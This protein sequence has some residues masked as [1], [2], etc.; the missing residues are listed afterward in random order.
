M[1]EC[2]VGDPIG[3]GNDIGV[4]DIKYMGYL[5]NHDDGNGRRN[6]NPSSADINKSRR[7]QEEA[8]K[9]WEEKKL[10]DA[11]SYINSAIYYN[12]ND[13]ENW[14]VKGL[15]LWEMA[16]MDSS[17]FYEACQCFN[18]ALI[19]KPDGKII[20]KNKAR[21]I[22]D[23]ARYYY[24]INDYD[25][26]MSR[27][28]ESLS[29]IEDKTADYYAT[30]LNLKSCIYF[31]EFDYGKAL[32]YINK[33]LKIS[34]NDEIIQQNRENIL[35]TGYVNDE[36]SFCDA[37]EYNLKLGNTEKASKYYYD[38]GF[39]FEYRDDEKEKAVKY[40]KKAIDINPNYNEA[41][42]H[43][44]YTLK[45][46]RRYR[47]AI[48]YFERANTWDDNE[49]WHIANCYMEL[50]EYS[51]A[52]PYLDKCIERAPLRDD[53]TEQKFECLLATNKNEAIQF[54]HSFAKSLRSKGY[55]FK[56]LKYLDKILEVKSDD[57]Y[58]YSQK[59][60]YLKNNRITSLY[61]ILNAVYQTKC[62]TLSGS[63]E[64][65]KAFMED[66]S[67]R[68]GESIENILNFYKYPEDED[69]DFKRL[70]DVYISDYKWEKIFNIYD[71][72]STGEACVIE[73]SEED[74]DNESLNNL[75]DALS[76]TKS[77]DEMEE[78]YWSLV[79]EKNS[80]DV[81]DEVNIIRNDEEENKN[82]RLKSTDNGVTIIELEE[83]I[84]QIQKETPLKESAVEDEKEETRVEKAPIEETKVVEEVVDKEPSV[85]EVNDEEE[86]TN[87]N[88]LSKIKEAKKLLD[89]GAITKQEY[90]E[91]KW[92]YLDL[93]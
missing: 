88:Y 86:I 56:A 72:R 38:L 47:E 35:N 61:N 49:V 73:I 62:S 92:K 16:D 8:V 21:C 20:K 91:I 39:K 44:G 59:Q 27:I 53:W 25:L 4:P 45:D 28:D 10:D 74:N 85:D 89:K 12:P 24:A 68:S 19:I 84:E 87:I 55:Y 83:E 90:D 42:I 26:A 41:L 32:E 48:T 14:N 58:A 9:L 17:K 22:T 33:A 78:E 30:A 77:L 18:N 63:D 37:A 46:L 3:N 57:T 23:W 5:K 51:S 93:I 81:L 79:D 13:D 43:L 31:S 2:Q 70:F 52:I 29:L 50:K 6:N 11:L 82:N 76:K 54:Y 36:D 65:L 1:R 40:F 75:T 67:K 80:Y 69:Y 7:F 60:K 64:D 34:P 71:I 66:I 15:I